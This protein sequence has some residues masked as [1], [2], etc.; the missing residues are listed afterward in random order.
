MA[1]NLQAAATAE[2]VGHLFYQCKLPITSYGIIL[3][4]FIAEPEFLMIRR[5]DSFGYIDFIRGKYSLSNIF[6]IQKCI[7]EMSAEEKNRITTKTFDV[8]WRELWGVTQHTYYIAQKKP[9]L[10]KSLKP[11]QAGIVVN[12]EIYHVGVIL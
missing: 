9:L 10:Q 12:G 6:Q 4:R 2:R 3:F 11:L 8:L 1:I 5:K 7:D